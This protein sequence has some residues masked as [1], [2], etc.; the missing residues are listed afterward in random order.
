MLIDEKF[1]SKKV[2]LFNKD[3]CNRNQVFAV[4]SAELEK[5]GVVK[6]TFREAIEKREKNYP[7]GLALTSGIGVAIPHTDPEYINENQIGFMS[8]E[9]PVEF[10]QMGSDTEVVP[11][12]LVFVLCLKEAHK[13]LDM[14]QNLMELFGKKEV[15]NAFISCNNEND[16]IKIINGK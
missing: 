3:L 14:L 16:F 12:R 7:T 13:Q 6:K 4:I 5:K 1:F 11:V 8:L 15:I 10:R 9:K 2:L